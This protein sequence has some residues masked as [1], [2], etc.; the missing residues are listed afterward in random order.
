MCYGVYLCVCAIV[1]VCD[2]LYD[3]EI[4]SP[5]SVSYDSDCFVVTLW[6]INVCVCV[7][8]YFFPLFFPSFSMC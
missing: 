7:C 8:V 4:V 2:G 3:Y 6:Q 1:C 5:C